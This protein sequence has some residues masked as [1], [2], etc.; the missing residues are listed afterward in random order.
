M[1]ST[2]RKSDDEVLE[3]LA[4]ILSN[5]SELKL[6]LSTVKN[7]LAQIKD[8][9]A[10][11]NAVRR[12]SIWHLYYLCTSDYAFEILSKLLLELSTKNMELYSALTLT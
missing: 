1:V 4:S 11:K 10:E 7:E 2:K 9:V 5:V 8:L 6:E 12:P 3:L